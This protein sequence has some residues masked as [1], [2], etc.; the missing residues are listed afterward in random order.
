VQEIAAIN[1]IEPGLRLIE[2]AR[3]ETRMRERAERTGSLILKT[4]VPATCLGS[5]ANDAARSSDI[6]S[7][8]GRDSCTN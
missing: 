4:P 7:S 3:P 8:G 1:G 6:C 5:A 2:C